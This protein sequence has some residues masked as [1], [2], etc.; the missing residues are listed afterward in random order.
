M[1]LQGFS[2][3]NFLS[4]PFLLAS[5]YSEIDYNWRENERNDSEEMYE[6]FHFPLEANISYE[7]FETETGDD[8]VVTIDMQNSTP[9]SIHT[10]A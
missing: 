5:S 9:C 3:W 10:V 8:V 7:C 6:Y 2:F 1:D 4:V